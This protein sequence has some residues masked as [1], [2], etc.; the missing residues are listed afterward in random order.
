MY[1]IGAVLLY[2]FGKAGYV[3]FPW[4]SGFLYVL[5]ACVAILFYI[6]IS[7]GTELPTSII[8]KSFQTKKQQNLT[9]LTALFTDSGLI[10]DRL[11]DLIQSALVADRGG[12]FIL[13]GR[14]NVVW[15][16]MELYK[17]LFH[18]TLTE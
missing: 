9:D 17:R 7:L 8:L 1:L 12:R 15:R 11:D 13:T 18:R 14:G 10:Y 5:L 6:A 16:V 4:S 3:S 2:E